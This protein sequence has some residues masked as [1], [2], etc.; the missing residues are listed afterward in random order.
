MRQHLH[1]KL[2]GGTG[3]RLDARFV[4]L[5]RDSPANVR[6]LQNLDN[7]EQVAYASEA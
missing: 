1:G 4:L 6:L 2:N 7:S 3:C 5:P